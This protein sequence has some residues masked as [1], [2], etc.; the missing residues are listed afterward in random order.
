[1]VYSRE[2]ACFHYVAFAVV[3]AGVSVAG[4]DD[5]LAI[6]AYEEEI[7]L[8]V[9]SILTDSKITLTI[10]SRRAMTNVIPVRLRLAGGGVLTRIA[11]TEVA[12]GLEIHYVFS[13]ALEVIRG[14]GKDQL[15]LKLGRVRTFGDSRL[16]IVS[17]HPFREPL[18]FAVAVKGVGSQSSERNNKKKE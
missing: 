13:I 16:D 9:K 6:L 7:K 15:F 3:G 12:F 18:Q 11:Q 1:M 17:L 10:I 5:C 4:V 2:A 14:C 8:R